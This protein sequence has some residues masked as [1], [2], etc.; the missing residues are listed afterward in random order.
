[1]RYTV[2]KTNNSYNCMYKHIF[3]SYLHFQ[4]S[5]PLERIAGSCFMS[6]TLCL[7]WWKMGKYWKI[8]ANPE[9]LTLMCHR[10]DDVKTRA[11]VPCDY[12]LDVDWTMKIE[13]KMCLKQHN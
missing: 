1:M 4:L 10:N 9:K 5:I 2:L 3:Q 12:I 13:K 6:Q 11:C 7:K 8:P